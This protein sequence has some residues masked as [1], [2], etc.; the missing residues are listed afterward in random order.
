MAQAISERVAAV[1]E[2]EAN[3]HLTACF[4]PCLQGCGVTDFRG[5]EIVQ[6]DTGTVVKQLD[7]FAYMRNDTLALGREARTNGLYLLVPAGVAARAA[8]AAPDRNLQGSPGDRVPSIPTKY[9][10]GEAYSGAKP[11]TYAIKVGQL[12]SAIE[13][14]RARHVDRGGACNDI[15][16]LVGAALLICSCGSR[17]RAQAVNEDSALFMTALDQGHHPNLWRLAEA[18][19]LF[20]LVISASESPQTVIGRQTYQTL[21]SLQDDV[22][23]MQDDVSAMQSDLEKL[24]KHFG[25]E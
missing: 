11:A 8:A 18:R 21:S 13:T 12:E 10:V 19:R 24:M 15:T 3:T 25:L 23:A 14:L 16:S 20:C 1:F 9:V 5:R 6:D 2:Q 22:S 7:S 17:S 4:P